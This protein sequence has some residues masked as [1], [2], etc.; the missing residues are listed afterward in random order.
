[1]N[2]NLK[3]ALGFLLVAGALVCGLTV[4]AYVNNNP[5]D[6]PGSGTGTDEPGTD[7]PSNP[8]NPFNFK[9]LK[10]ISSI[11]DNFKDDLINKNDE[12]KYQLVV[13]KDSVNSYV[14]STDCT[15]VMQFIEKGAFGLATDGYYDLQSFDVYSIKKAVGSDQC[16][17]IR[18]RYQLDVSKSTTQTFS[19]FVYS[20][21][22][23]TKVSTAQPNVALKGIDVDLMTNLQTGAHEDIFDI[24]LGKNV[25]TKV[26]INH[27]TLTFN[28]DSV[29]EKDYGSSYFILKD[30][31]VQ[32]TSMYSDYIERLSFVKEDNYP[33]LNY[34]TFFTNKK[35]ED[36]VPG[37][38]GSTD[39]PEEPNKL[40]YLR[41]D[42]TTRENNLLK[43]VNGDWN[44]I[45]S[46]F[47]DC[48]DDAAS[49]FGTCA[50]YVADD[51]NKVKI[52][53]QNQDNEFLKVLYQFKAYLADEKG[54]N[55]G[56]YAEFVVEVYFNNISNDLPK[57]RVGQITLYCLNSNGKYEKMLEV[58]HASI[59]YFNNYN[60]SSLVTIS[61]T[62]FRTPTMFNGKKYNQSVVFLETYIINPSSQN[63]SID[64]LTSID[65]D[66]DYDA[67]IDSYSKDGCTAAYKLITTDLP[68]EE[69]VF[70]LIFGEYG[71]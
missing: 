8:S 64:G 45:D 60:N 35:I 33:T 56:K 67:S 50:S 44:Y 28:I 37:D 38:G 47:F 34:N 19:Y 71:V 17:V 9:G 61:S 13:N 21:N 39:K 29:E 54:N 6:N 57:N 2:S 59:V 51:S 24:T 10:F 66:W 70:Q 25:S 46:V 30:N 63:T 49:L 22:K 41:K 7:E 52:I 43:L 65:S 1:M 31:C 23:A 32:A 15:N 3:K 42:Y 48:G 12:G 62:L 16:V 20:E 27:E 4:I 69:S 14:D 40:S 68:T 58:N 36:V 53:M 55:T 26:N 18:Y 5:S 11:F